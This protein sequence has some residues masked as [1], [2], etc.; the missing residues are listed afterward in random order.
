MSEHNTLTKYGLLFPLSTLLLS[1]TEINHVK[2]ESDV[3][4]AVAC[5]LV[6]HLVLDS[7]VT[8]YEILFITRN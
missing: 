2:A 1:S 6:D 4:V 8:K 7:A 3:W 5:C